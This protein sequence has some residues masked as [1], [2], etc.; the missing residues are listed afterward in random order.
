MEKNGYIK[1]LYSTAISFG[2]KVIEYRL[3]DVSSNPLNPTGLIII[4][5]DVKNNKSFKNPLVC[6]VTKKK[7][8]LIKDSY[9][10]KEGLLVY[11]IVDN[12]PCL[13]KENAIIATHYLDNFNKI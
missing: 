5:K 13:L 7:L 10:T 8:E 1:N 9:F 4:K 3:F 11:P 6:P 12:V 2:L